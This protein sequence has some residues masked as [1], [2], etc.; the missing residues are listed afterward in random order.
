ML[1][2]NTVDIKIPL[3]WPVIPVVSVWNKSP[4]SMRLISDNQNKF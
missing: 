2:L 1:L 4:V 3:R